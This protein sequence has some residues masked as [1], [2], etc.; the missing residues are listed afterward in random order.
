[1]W[2]KRRKRARQEVIEQATQW[3]GEKRDVPLPPT[4][5]SDPADPD[6]YTPRRRRK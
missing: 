4:N 1:M 6:R 2:F 3:P 5:R